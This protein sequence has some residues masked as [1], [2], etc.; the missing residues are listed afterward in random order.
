MNKLVNEFKEN[1]RLTCQLLVSSM[2]KGVT[3][4]GRTYLNMELRDSSGALSAKKWDV[5]PGDE[6]TFATGN[7]VECYFDVIDYKGALQ[8]KVHA[9]KVVN[10]EEIDVVRFLKY[11]PIPLEQLKDKFIGYINSIEDEDIAKIVKYLYKKFENKILS[12]PAAVSIHHEYYA[13]LLHHT[14]SMCDHALYLS[15]YY[16]NINRD[17]L[18]G[19][20]ILHDFGK[21]IELGGDLVKTF[22]LEGKLIGHISIVAMEI[23]KACEYLNIHSEATTL[24]KHVVLAH[25]GSLEYGSP[26]LPK[27]KEALLL[28]LIDNLDSKMVLV[29][30]AL[31]SVNKGEFT[32]KIFALD[33]REFYKHN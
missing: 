30:K 18:M 19:G 5:M 22:T 10:N 33:N 7:V 16:P 6:E 14:T 2:V 8:L 28:N 27:T 20:V 4:Q 15:N 13:G 3:Q 11:P 24:L 12:Y 17:L 32:Q 26:V 9:G 21:T 29:E 25:H 31:E 23:D 1:D